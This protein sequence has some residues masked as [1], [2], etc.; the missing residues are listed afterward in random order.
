M[1]MKDALLVL[2]GALISC[3]TTWF[4]ELLR[5]RR[6]EKLYYK[7]KKEE[8]Y[9]EMQDFLVDCCAHW[10]ELK[11]GYVSVDIRLKY[12]SIRTKAHIYSKKEIV[13]EFYSLA[14]ELI[15]GKRSDNY[16]DRNDALIVMIK[17]DLKIEDK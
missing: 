6:E 11:T 14:I 10:N 7:R 3:G 5:Y 15:T 12:N 9:I 4:L 8:A 16:S 13:D 1:L 17:E 2:L